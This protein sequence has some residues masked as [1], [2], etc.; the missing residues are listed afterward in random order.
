ME[1]C[2]GGFDFNIYLLIIIF[3]LKVLKRTK[4]QSGGGVKVGGS[5]MPAGEDNQL[6]S[7]HPSDLKFI[8]EFRLFFMFMY[9]LHA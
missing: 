8:C 6:I 4:D 5:V 1:D 7:V 9:V 3:T 2:W